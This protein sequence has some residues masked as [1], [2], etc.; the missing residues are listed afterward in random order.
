MLENSDFIIGNKLIRYFLEMIGSLCFLFFIISKKMNVKILQSQWSLF[1]S[2]FLKWKWC[3][4]KKVASSAYSLN[5]YTVFSPKI[6]IIFQCAFEMFMYTRILKRCLLGETS[7]LFLTV[8]GGEEH[9]DYYTIWCDSLDLCCGAGIW[10][11]NA[12]R[13]SVQMSIQCQIMS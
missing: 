6:N 7:I 13:S 3:S 9:V 12:F 8:C 2:C 1:V 5:S 11:T 4:V 10:P